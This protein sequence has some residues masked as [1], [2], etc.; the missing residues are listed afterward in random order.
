MFS[1]NVDMVVFH[2]PYAVSGSSGY[3]CRNEH[4][5]LLYERLVVTDAWIFTECCV[6][7]Y[8]CRICP[9]RNGVWQSTDST[10]CEKDPEK[11]WQDAERR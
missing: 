6:D 1:N 5:Y 9:Y 8:H 11:I 10:T 4:S 7:V 2:N 3:N